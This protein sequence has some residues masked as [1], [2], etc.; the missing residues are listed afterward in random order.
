MFNATDILE[1][2]SDKKCYGKDIC[3][4]IKINNHTGEYTIVLRTAD[5]FEKM[6]IIDP[7]KTQDSITTNMRLILDDFRMS[8]LE[9]V[10]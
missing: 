5:G 10:I 8:Y 1:W 7:L 4:Y 2:L 9:A 6:Y 3:S